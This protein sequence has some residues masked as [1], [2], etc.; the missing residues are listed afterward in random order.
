MAGYSHTPGASP[1]SRCNEEEEE[2]TRKGIEITDALLIALADWCIVVRRHRIGQSLLILL[3]LRAGVGQVNDDDL[4]HQI[5][6]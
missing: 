1:I 3:T 6:A 4:R 5:N 2:D